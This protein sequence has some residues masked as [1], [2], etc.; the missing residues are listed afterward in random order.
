MKIATFIL[1]ILAFSIASMDLVLSIV[2]AKRVQEN[3]VNRFVVYSATVLGAVFFVLMES[4]SQ[5][6]F[7]GVTKLVSY[8]IWDILLI[9]DAAFLFN[10]IPYVVTK[11]I[12]HPWRNPYKAIF[13][14]TSILYV[15]TAIYGYCKYSLVA[16]NIRFLC[17]FFIVFFCIF[18][19]LKNY[20]SIAMKH[21][22]H[23]LL[24]IAIV[25]FTLVPIIVA[26]L[27]FNELKGFCIPILLLAS[28]I[29][30]LV[31]LFVDI[32]KR[33]EKITTYEQKQPLTIDNL[34]Q[35]HITEREYSVILLIKEGLT[36]KEI[37]SKL[38][39]SVNTVN[40]HIAN[41]FSKT[42]VRSRIDLLNLL[43]ESTYVKV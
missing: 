15:V 38:N 32:V 37:A 5:M 21:V 36:N 22:R 10:Y 41:I 16:T 3:W 14:A 6:Y 26:G 30:I 1:S 28:T 8:Y 7:T 13:L 43:E 4:F 25:S 23:T 17:F 34:S 35:Y 27:F 18:V 2:Y 40:N 20:G 12:A 11:I 19:V 9:I 31:Y 33:E 29:C 24:A 42:T 39:I